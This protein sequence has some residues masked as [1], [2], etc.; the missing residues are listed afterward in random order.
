MTLGKTPVPVR[1]CSLSD[2]C[3]IDGVFALEAA[4]HNAWVAVGTAGADGDCAT[5]DDARIALV[6]VGD[7]PSESATLLPAET[8]FVNSRVTDAE[9]R[10]LWLI[11]AENLQ[12]LPFQGGPTTQLVAYKPNLDRVVVGASVGAAS[13]SWSSTGPLSSGIWVSTKSVT[14]SWNLVRLRGDMQSLSLSGRLASVAESRD[15]EPLG[16][17]VDQGVAYD[18]APNGESVL[19]ISTDGS[20]QTLGALSP[21]AGQPDFFSHSATHVLVSQRTLASLVTWTSMN[22]ADGSLRTLLS[23]VGAPAVEFM[24]FSAS[25]FIYRTQTNQTQGELRSVDLATGAD[26]VL[27]AQYVHDADL[28]QVDASTGELLVLGRFPASG[29]HERRANHDVRLCGP[30]AAGP[31]P[32]AARDHDITHDAD[33]RQLQLRSRSRRFT[34][35]R[36]QRHPVAAEPPW[37]APG[38]SGSQPEHADG[39]Y[40]RCSLLLE[41]LC[42]RRA[43]L[44]LRCVL[45]RQLVHLRHGPADLCDA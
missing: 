39:L 40:Q 25:R 16:P 36:D 9:G 29:F 1:V 26:N 13:S 17:K 31:D 35:S 19:R 32:H 2:A 4:G 43:L 34:A 5:N 33:Q 20:T 6:R 38:P 3:R 7:T 41:T 18:M 24:A 44:H 15:F 10:L 27:L 28:V 22:K 8:L 42:S 11:A 21:A 37:T 14:G 30:R 12:R 45:L 23:G